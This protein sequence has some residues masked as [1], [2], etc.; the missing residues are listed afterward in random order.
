MRPRELAHE[1]NK[2]QNITDSLKRGNT[3]QPLIS[4]NENA[5]ALLHTPYAL[6]TMTYAT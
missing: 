5:L 4:L 2:Q 6:T 3:A 1:R